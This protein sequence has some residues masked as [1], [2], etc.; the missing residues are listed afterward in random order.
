MLLGDGIALLIATVLVLFFAVPVTRE[1]YLSANGQLPVLLSFI[2]FALLATGGEILASRLKNKEYSFKKFGLLPKMLIWGI[3]GVIIYWAFIIFA[4]GTPRVFPILATLNEPF[5]TILTAFTISV[6]MNLIF[7][8][9]FM[10]CHHITDTFITDNHGTFPIKKFKMLAA[11][12]RIDWDRMWGFVYKKTIPFFWIPAHTIT[13]MLP[14]QYRVLF[15][16]FLSIILGILLGSVQVKK[17]P[18]ISAD[19]AA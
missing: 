1:F 10:L 9:V 18:A 13:F 8:P 3:F 7:S 2:K 14:A 4:N 11:L 15:A 17:T 16:A 19:N 5:K 6:F 12:K